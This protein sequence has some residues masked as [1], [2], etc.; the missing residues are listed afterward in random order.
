MH[1]TF[2]SVIPLYVAAVPWTLPNPTVVTISYCQLGD[3]RKNA[4][5]RT[6]LLQAAS[7][8]LKLLHLW[9]ALCGKLL[10]MR[11]CRISCC[12]W[13]FHHIFLPAGSWVLAA[14]DYQEVSGEFPFFLSLFLSDPRILDPKN[15]QRATASWKD[16][17]FI[18]K[19][20]HNMAD[21]SSLMVHFM[22]INCAACINSN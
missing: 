6:R 9:D 3:W 2:H 8:H 7:A 1:T 16:E 17:K 5:T 19:C 18:I 12:I 14:N 11:S 21:G 13:R 20:P 15:N 4:K 22:K 10:F